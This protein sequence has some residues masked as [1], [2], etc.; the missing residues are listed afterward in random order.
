MYITDRNV[1]ISSYRTS[2]SIVSFYKI[3][4]YQKL[5]L[6]FKFKILRQYIIFCDK[7]SCRFSYFMKLSLECYEK[8]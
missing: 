2:Y 6:K 8:E 4:I 5:K 1:K 7:G 3:K